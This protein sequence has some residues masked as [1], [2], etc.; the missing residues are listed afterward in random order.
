MIFSKN[1]D[2]IISQDKLKNISFVITGTLE[3]FKNRN[4]L[5]DLITSNGGKVVSGVSKNVNYLINN[6]IKKNNPTV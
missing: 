4:E 1:N 5:S 3:S 2:K 6:N